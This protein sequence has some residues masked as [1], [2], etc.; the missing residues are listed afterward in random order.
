M[1]A[2]NPRGQAYSL[3]VGADINRNT[4]PVSTSNIGNVFP[5]A[6]N[7]VLSVSVEAQKPRTILLSNVGSIPL[8]V[9][10]SQR[11]FPFGLRLCSGDYLELFTSRALWVAAPPTVRGLSGAAGIV[12]SV[13]YVSV[14]SAA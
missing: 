3:P 6:Q 7:Q 9:T 4:D 10:D 12:A 5:V 2:W 11:T 13:G 8:V 14:T 1:A